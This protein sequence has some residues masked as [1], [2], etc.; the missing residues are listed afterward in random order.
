M[1]DQ[2]GAQQLF[3]LWKKQV[4]EGTRAWLKMAGQGQSPDPQAFWRPFMDQGMQ[5]WSKVMTQGQPSPDLMSQWKQ[6]EGFLNQ[7]GPVKKAAE[8][9]I[10]A[11]L[12]GLGVP[13]RSQVVGIAKQ[14]IALEE[15]IDAVD[16]RIDT[17]LKRLEEL[18]AAVRKDRA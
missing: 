9:H 18:T 1:A 7:A 6:L 11:T 17:M 15:K 16:D 2:A 12:A 8:Q 13:S 4:E 14:I 5:A 3:D 10:E